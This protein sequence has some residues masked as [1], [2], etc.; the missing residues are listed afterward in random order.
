MSERRART[1][2]RG[3]ARAARRAARAESAP[4]LPYITR[5]VPVYDVL[6]EEGLEP[7]RGERRDHPRRRSASSSARTRKR[8]RF[9]RGAGADRRRRE[10][11]RFPARPV[12]GKLVQDTA[13]ATVHPARPQPRAQRED[14]GAAHGVRTRLWAALR[15]Q[16][17]RRTALRDDRGLPQLREARV[18]LPRPSPLGRHPVRAGGPAR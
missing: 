8:W 17:R 12:P 9:W 11:V 10:R 2:A 14:R 3:G 15:A 6:G 18:P 5:K 1:R 4:A 13:P 16:P 7:H